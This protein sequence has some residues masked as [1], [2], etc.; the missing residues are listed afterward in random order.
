MNLQEIEI[1]ID[2]LE[3]ICCKLLFLNKFITVT[4][5]RFEIHN[6][7]RRIQLNIGLLRGGR[8]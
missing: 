5:V 3:E 1:V 8:I 2:N 4:A 6:L 7:V